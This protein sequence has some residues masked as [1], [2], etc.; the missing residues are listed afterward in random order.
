MISQA[1]VRRQPETQ[2]TSPPLSHQPDSPAAFARVRLLCLGTCLVSRASMDGAV[3][4]DGHDAAN[5]V[6]T[7][8]QAQ[9]CPVA[10]G[11]SGGIFVFVP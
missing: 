3:E 9:N 7:D 2:D 11:P 10:G 8:A 1:Q 5:V 4:A 6:G